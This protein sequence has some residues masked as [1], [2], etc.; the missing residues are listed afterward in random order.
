[1]GMAR[2]KTIGKIILMIGIIV[3]LL[4]ILT[5]IT[6]LMI[7]SRG[8]GSLIAATFFMMPNNISRPTSNNYRIINLPYK[9]I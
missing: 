6:C 7:L 1:M 3:V 8:L 4:G 5:A 2:L 9:S